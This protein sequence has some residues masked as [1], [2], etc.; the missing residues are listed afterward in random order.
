MEQELKRSA[1]RSAG[2][3]TLFKREGGKKKDERDGKGDAVG[4]LVG[5]AKAKHDVSQAIGDRLR[6]EFIAPASYTSMD[7]SV[8]A[9]I[10]AAASA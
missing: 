8:P 9:A 3:A 6:A 10:E 5:Y 7:Y 1:W 4:V 2:A